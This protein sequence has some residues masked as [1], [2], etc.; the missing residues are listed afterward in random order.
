MFYTRRVSRLSYQRLQIKLL[1]L[2]IGS[3]RA[4]RMPPDQSAAA[5]LALATAGL[6]FVG[7]LA[8]VLFAWDIFTQPLR[9]V[10]LCS[11]VLFG[12]VWPVYRWVVPRWSAAATVAHHLIPAGMFVSC[13]FAAVYA[14]GQLP[15]AAIYSPAIPLLSV[16]ICG[17]RGAITWSGLMGM[18]L[19]A[20]LVFGPLGSQLPEPPPAMALLGGL[21]VL[22]PTLL[23]MLLHRSVW[24]QAVENERQLRE[25]LATA[26]V[27]Q[28]DLDKRLS[29]HERTESLT[30]MAGRVAHDLNNFLTSVNGNAGLARHQLETGQADAAADSVAAIDQA[31]QTA[32]ELARQL[33]NY[34]GNRHLT[35]A[36][37][38]LGVRVENT[39]VLARA[40]VPDTVRIEIDCSQGVWVHGDPTQIDQVVVNLVRNAAAA[41]GEQVADKAVR[42]SV[43]KLTLD[44]AKVCAL[45]TILAPGDYA[46]LT[47]QDFGSG[48][49][50][51]VRSRMFEPFY[52]TNPDGQGLGLASVSGIVKGHG[53]GVEVSSNV[54]QGTTV[55]VY[56]PLQ[57]APEQS[58]AEVTAEL[59]GNSRLASEF[60]LVADDQAEVRKV[61]GRLVS[62]AGLVPVYA[63]DGQEAL[64]LLCQPDAQFALAVLDISMPRLDGLSVLKSL[65]DREIEMPVLLV[66][67]Y[68]NADSSSSVFS[69]GHALFLQ[70][71][72]SA[73]AFNEALTQLG[74]VNLQV[75]ASP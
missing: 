21:T 66:S 65:R 46:S 3:D 68:A 6:G 58:I 30:L 15:L 47:I 23:S 54:R 43:S 28:R 14:A 67:G 20:G 42:I 44:D 41:Y 1:T 50:D 55:R 11:L 72:F 38:D 74:L 62:R 9:I 10:I 59:T 24:A 36:G 27:R 8:T 2:V 73:Q 51:E 45:E 29:Q 63:V 19:L 52:S 49:S 18:M 56:L 70:K 53:G 37:V 13:G 22:I 32:S 26:H 5:F 7:V 64:E 71:P 4:Q 57:E 75:A 48:I 34:S 61:L 31:A 16:M 33:L 35:L 60:V 12:A 25:S 40:A 17:T 39:M 69:D